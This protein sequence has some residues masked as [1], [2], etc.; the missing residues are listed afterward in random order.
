VPFR[1]KVFVSIFLAFLVLLLVGPFLIPA[2]PLEGTAPVT[3]LADEDAAFASVAGV[4][5][6]FLRGGARSGAAVSGAALLLLPGYPSNAQSW[7]PVMPELALYGQT[8]AVDPIGFGLSERPLPGSWRRGE[9]PYLP[10]AQVQQAVALLD[11]LGVERAVWIGSSSGALT[12]LSAALLH[13]E[14]VA[15]LV[16]VG[17]PVYGARS[18]PAW[19]RPLLHTPQMNRLGPLLMRQLGEGPGRRLF[20]SQWA[21]PEL[22]DEQDLAAFDRTFQVDDWDRGLWEVSKASRRLS[23]G[24]SLP[25]VEVPVLVVAG[26][27]DPIV[28]PED[29]QR[30]A[31]EIPRATLALMDG[32]G[33][34]PHVECPAA[35]TAVL[36][37]WLAG[38]R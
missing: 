28:T 32:C 10:D 14:R 33:H 8:V 34:L 12:A 37:D 31:R 21:Q 25:E 26:A 35:F 38:A 11:D 16:L 24:E 36:A 23:L 20:T 17:A 15:G 4:E 18:P 27:A 1:I 13:P 30:L 19:L 2:P 22:V 6:H 7:R 3:S 29:S 9:N 5:L